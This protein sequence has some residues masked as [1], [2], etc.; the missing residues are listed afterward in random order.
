MPA[1]LKRKKIR[2]KRIPLQRKLTLEAIIELGLSDN[3]SGQLLG[4]TSSSRIVRK[5]RTD[6]REK[7]LLAARLPEAERTQF[8]SQLA[9]QQAEA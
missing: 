3:F 6:L 7:K 2:R 4:L 1:E 9:A 5:L 8:T